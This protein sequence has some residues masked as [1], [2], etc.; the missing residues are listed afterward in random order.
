MQAVDLKAESSENDWIE[1]EALRA[2]TTPRLLMTWFSSGM[3]IAMAIELYGYINTSLLGLWLLISLATVLFQS[4]IK[5]V[6]NQHFIKTPIADQIRF[7]KRNQM[8]WTLNGFTWGIASWLIFTNIPVESHYLGAIVLTLIGLATVQNLHTHRSISRQFI[9]LLMG[10]QILGAI[11]YFAYIRQFQGSR[12]QYIHLLS[13]CVI[14]V[15]LHIINTRMFNSF[16][17]NLSLQ[18]RNNN[19][20]RSL[21]L[22]TEQLV[23]EKQVATNANDVIQRF[24]SSSAH[25]IRQPVY[26]LKLYAQMGAADPSQ[27]PCL[28]PKIT[29]SCDSIHKLFD[30]LFEFEQINA[31]HVQ[32]TQETVDIDE[33]IGDLER[34][35]KPLACRKNLEFRTHAISGYLQTDQLLIK[36]ILTCFISNAIKY[37]N[38]GGVL[39]AVRE[40]KAMV[41][42]EVWD[43]GIG[44]DSLHLAHVFDEFYKVGN[45]SSRD[46]GFGLG[47]SVVKRLSAYAEGSRVSVNSRPGTGSVFRFE[48]PIK[49]YTRPHTLSKLD[50]LQSLPSNVDCYH[51]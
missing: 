51:A 40:K 27:L 1:S 22:K 5:K 24:Y 8:A 38:S 23:H 3:M 15:V 10:T 20:I 19:L 45:F 43:T 12:L 16:Q 36:R 42:F 32:V 17:R 49:T 41:V 34:Q 33:V 46:E 11:W 25:D 44:V 37:T 47:L 7:A 21:N 26:A 9:N 13:L 39:V 35:F 6:F 30:S 31:G 14:W 2:L 18:F 28:L 50:N 29:A 4:R 48:L